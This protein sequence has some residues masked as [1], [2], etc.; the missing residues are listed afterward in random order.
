[1]RPNQTALDEAIRHC[2]DWDLAI[3]SH[4]VR[5]L[6][7]RGYTDLPTA[8][9]ILVRTAELIAQDAWAGR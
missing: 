3:P 8:D 7:L 9:E 1:M 4:V 6:T 5:L 2:I